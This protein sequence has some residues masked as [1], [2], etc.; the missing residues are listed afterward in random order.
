[1]CVNRSIL[2]PRAASSLDPLCPATSMVTH[3]APAHHP[4]TSLFSRTAGTPPL[5]SHIASS[6]PPLLVHVCSY[7]HSTSPRPSI[8]TPS[9]SPTPKP[10]SFCIHAYTPLFTISLSTP[11]PTHASTHNTT[12]TTG[13]LP[14][15]PPHPP[16]WRRR[17]L[18]D[19]RPPR[20]LQ[21]GVYVYA[22]VCIYIHV[23]MYMYVCVCLCMCV[24]LYIINTLLTPSLLLA[25]SIQQLP[26]LPPP[27]GPIRRLQRGAP[28]R[29]PSQERR[30]RRG[31]GGGAVL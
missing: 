23:C 14:Q 8:D 11:N 9:P 2:L 26:H 10:R 15:P 29:L 25:L 27:M 22:C 31:G 30:G 17:H 16:L 19:V 7:L 28:V 3:S 20:P 18:A 6:H 1:M 12:P 24:F 21:V 5:L 4:A 13:F